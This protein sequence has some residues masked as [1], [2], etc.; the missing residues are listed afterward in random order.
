MLEYYGKEAYFL[1]E[2]GAYPSQVTECAL[3]VCV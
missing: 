2:E 1:L 3:C